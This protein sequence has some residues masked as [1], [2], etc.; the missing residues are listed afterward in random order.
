MLDVVMFFFLNYP[1]V[2]YGNGIILLILPNSYLSIMHNSR[3]TQQSLKM[4][5]E[6]EVR[7]KNFIL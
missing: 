5:D 1:M 3:P 6:S 2:L 7:A 4:C